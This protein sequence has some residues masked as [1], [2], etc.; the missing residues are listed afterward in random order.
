MSQNVRYRQYWMATL[1]DCHQCQMCGQL[2][3]NA[4]ENVDVY[5]TCETVSWFCDRHFPPKGIMKENEVRK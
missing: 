2:A 3:I 5:G 1:K 4:L